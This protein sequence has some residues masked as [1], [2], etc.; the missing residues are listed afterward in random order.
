MIKNS[1]KKEKKTLLHKSQMFL[2][3]KDFVANQTK[4]TTYIFEILFLYIAKG[5]HPLTFVEN[6][7]L[8]Y[9]DLRQCGHAMFSILVPIVE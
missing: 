7:S 2:A 6:L 1:P 9:M 3:T 8:N 5:Y 4:H